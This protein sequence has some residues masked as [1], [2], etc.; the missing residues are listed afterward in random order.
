MFELYLEFV[1]IT[2]ISMCIELKRLFFSQEHR[3]KS[4]YGYEIFSYTTKKLTLYRYSHLSNK[5][6]F[7]LTDFRK[8]H[9]AGNKNLTCM[10]IDFI[11][12]LSIFLQNPL[13]WS[14]WAI[15]LYSSIKIYGKSLVDI[16]TFASLHIYSNLHGY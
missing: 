8:F 11:T 2:L 12:K 7:T 4:C 14:F 5:H 15:N 16:A 13:S 6:D 10:V 9:P 1:Y 3:Y